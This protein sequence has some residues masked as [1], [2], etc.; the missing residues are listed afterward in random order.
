MLKI[1]KSRLRKGKK[2]KQT[3]SFFM[4]VYSVGRVKEHLMRLT[5]ILSEAS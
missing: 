2:S 5:E 4:S 3:M 1:G